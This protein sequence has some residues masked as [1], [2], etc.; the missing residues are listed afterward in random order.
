M[1]RFIKLDK[2]QF[3]GREAAREEF[4]NGP[5][6]R[7]TAFIVE[8]DDADV[9]GDEPIWARVGEEIQ[10]EHIDKPHGQGAIR[11]SADGKAVENQVGTGAVEGEWRVV[12]WVTSGGYGHYI[13]QSLAQGYIPNALSTDESEGLFEIEIL[14][15]RRLARICVEAPFDP[16]G[17]SMRS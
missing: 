17:Q 15:E 12:G 4:E 8:A 10:L 11:F 9:M 16:Q 2:G 5:V 3:I 14:G 13:K 1:E 6:L 7:R